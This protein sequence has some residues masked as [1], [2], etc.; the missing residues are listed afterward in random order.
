MYVKIF[1][2]LFR[3]V[4]DDDVVGVWLLFVPVTDSVESDEDTDV[5][6]I[7]SVVLN[8]TERTKWDHLYL[9]IKYRK[10]KKKKKILLVSD[11]RGLRME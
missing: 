2:Q 6:L 10:K 11:K 4:F 9:I 5:D 1:S 7:E 3:R 8:G